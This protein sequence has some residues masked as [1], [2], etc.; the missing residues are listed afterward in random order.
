M[1]RKFFLQKNKNKKKILLIIKF[2]IKF[3]SVA[4]FNI[5]IKTYALEIIILEYFNDAAKLQNGNN[6]MFRA[7]Y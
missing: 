3:T 5:L 4:N 7:P 6:G 2:L 1:R